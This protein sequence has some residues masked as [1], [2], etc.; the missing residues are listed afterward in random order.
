M[1]TKEQ[2]ADEVIAR[3]RRCAEDPSALD[4]PEFARLVR[5]DVGRLY[6]LGFTATDAV[7]FIRLNEEL[8]PSFDEGVALAR[9]RRLYQKYNVN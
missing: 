2:F 6:G 4:E 3:V 7:R 1:T 5:R 9:L 8:S